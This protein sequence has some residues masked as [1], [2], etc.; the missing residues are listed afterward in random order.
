MSTDACVTPMSYNP[1]ELAT[2]G[3]RVRAVSVIASGSGVPDIHAEYDTD[4]FIYATPG[5]EGVVVYV[6]PKNN[7]ITVRFDRVG[8]ATIVF[9]EEVREASKR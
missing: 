5:D 6:E 9:P 1:P 3:T 8:H 4:G 7:I 2:V